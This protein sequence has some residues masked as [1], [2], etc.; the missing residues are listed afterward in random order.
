MHCMFYMKFLKYHQFTHSIEPQSC[1]W[2]YLFR[3]EM[4]HPKKIS[5]VKIEVILSDTN[6]PKTFLHTM[7]GVSFEITN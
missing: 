2:K 4:A 7:H 3:L 6:Y 1:A 5:A